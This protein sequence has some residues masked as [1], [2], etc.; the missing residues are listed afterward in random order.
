MIRIRLMTFADLELGE[1]K[2]AF[3]HGD[4]KRL[5]EGI[6]YSGHFDYLFYGHT[7][8][9]EEHRTGPTRV[10]ISELEGAAPCGCGFTSGSPRNYSGT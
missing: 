9:A 7:H 4:N 8:V 10:I 6:E 5:L 3:V 1:K 2:V